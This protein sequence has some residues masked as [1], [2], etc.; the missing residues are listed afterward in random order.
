MTGIFFSLI[1]VLPLRAEGT[2]YVGRDEA[3]FICKPMSTE[4]GM[5]MEL[6]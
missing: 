3:E 4:D 6:T 5:L 2:Y 1:W